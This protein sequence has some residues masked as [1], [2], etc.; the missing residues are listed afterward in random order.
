[1]DPC[2]EV[3]FVGP[4]DRLVEFEWNPLILMHLFIPLGHFRQTLP[5]VKNRNIFRKELSKHEAK[6]AEGK[7]N[8]NSLVNKLQ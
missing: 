4:V 6:F 3:K 2:K 8:M 1:M 7:K 5:G